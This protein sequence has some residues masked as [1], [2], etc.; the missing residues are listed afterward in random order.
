M[1]YYSIHL[2]GFDTILPKVRINVHSTKPIKQYY[3]P[4]FYRRTKTKTT[5]LLSPLPPKTTTTITIDTNGLSSISISSSCIINWCCWGWQ[6]CLKGLHK[7]FLGILRHWVEPFLKQL[8]QDL[9]HTCRRASQDKATH[10]KALHQD[11]PFPLLSNLEDPLEPPLSTEISQ[12][13]LP[14][15]PPVKSINRKKKIDRIQNLVFWFNTLLNY[16]FLKGQTLNWENIFCGFH[17]TN[18]IHLQF[19]KCI[20]ISLGKYTN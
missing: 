11:E 9:H 1:Y 3:T 2:K 10:L 19:V 7:P 20:F 8:C 13:I 15:H 4:P 5:F 14:L 17:L 6:C 18:V 12:T 16:G